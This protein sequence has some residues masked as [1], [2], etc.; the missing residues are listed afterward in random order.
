MLMRNGRWGHRGIY[1][2]CL[3]GHY[4]SQ[5]LVRTRKVAPLVTGHHQALSGRSKLLPSGRS[6]GLEVSFL[7][8][9]GRYR[10]IRS[11]KLQIT[12]LPPLNV[13]VLLQSR[14]IPHYMLVSRPSE[15]KYRSGGRFGNF[16]ATGTL[17]TI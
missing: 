15:T 4:Q 3:F 11:H 13:T 9:P 7:L 10:D 1:C 17:L 6:K 12:C 2:S 16:S 8:K 5:V 14:P